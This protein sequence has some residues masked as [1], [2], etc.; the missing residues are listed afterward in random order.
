MG[1]RQLAAELADAIGQLPPKYREAF[2]LFH[3]ENMAYQDIRTVTG[4]SVN[5]LKVR[6]HRARLMLMKKLRHL[7]EDE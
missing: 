4:V 7:L 2:T 3:L 5:A 6:V 1:G